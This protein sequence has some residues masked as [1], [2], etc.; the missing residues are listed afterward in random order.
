MAAVNLDDMQEIV[1]YGKGPAPC[2]DEL[3]TLS[4]GAENLINTKEEWEAFVEKNPFFI[5]GGA[6]STCEK[7][8]DSE[9]LLKE[10]E[11]AVKNKAIFS[12][13]EKNKKQKKIVRKEIKI[14]RVD[15]N[16]K[17]LTEKLAAKG[18]WFPMGTT[19]YIVDNGRL[20]K[21]DGMW[22]ETNLL[23]HQMQRIA[24]PLIEL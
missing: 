22:A 20:V 24:S 3:P 14:A 8:C 9:P 23:F 6:D 4:V 16:N 18:I 13:P 10:L 1:L 15:L 12:Y 21:Y 17:K 7:C 11:K 2:D 5:V 19:I